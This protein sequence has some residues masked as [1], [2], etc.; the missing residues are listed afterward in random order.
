[1][2]PRLPGLLGRFPVGTFL[3]SEPS[4]AAAHDR[5]GCRLT[6][7]FWYPALPTRNPI[8]RYDRSASI[9]STRHWIKTDARAR[10]PV[11]HD[12]SPYPLLLFFPGWSGGRNGNT[13][14]VQDLASRGFV[15]LT[16][17]YGAPA[18]A[19]LSSV[20]EAM[21]FSS[22][23]GFRRTYGIAQSRLVYVPQASERLLDLLAGSQ[24]IGAPPGF[25]RVIDVSRIGAIGYS[26]GGAIALELAARDS[27]IGAVINLDGWLF[28][29]G[30]LRWPSSPVLYISDDPSAPAGVEPPSGSTE[31]QYTTWLDRETDGLLKRNFARFGGTLLTI[32]GS[33][34]EDFA[35][36]PYLGLI[37]HRS[38]HGP[39]AEA[40]RLAVHY[41][42]EFFDQT[43]GD[44][45]LRPF[46]SPLP[47]VRIQTWHVA[48]AGKAE[49][50][51]CRV[52]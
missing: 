37:S 5:G 13:A 31:K 28:G 11:A 12:G 49:T 8:Y 50:E 51:Q 17:G 45:C 22:E 4:S 25:A 18:C 47:R 29:A 27:R 36:Y 48:E 40:L 23:A 19:G 46:T 35:D 26:F 7:Q 20:S 33:E 6:G 38:V 39:G 32:S 34:H 14:L 2:I 43:L 1:M 41:S 42:A 3:L 16:L 24:A 52:Q 10:A 30:D 9:L 44:R 15:V 21:D